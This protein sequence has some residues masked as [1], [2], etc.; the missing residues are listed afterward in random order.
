MTLSVAYP[1]NV[2]QHDPR[3][4]RADVR[5]FRARPG[6]PD[7][8]AEIQAALDSGASEITLG[9]TGFY[10]AAVTIPAGVTLTTSGAIL[11]PVPSVTARYVVQTGGVGA[12]LLGVTI[13]ASGDTGLLGGELAVQIRHAQARVSRC[14]FLATGYRYGVYIAAIGV[15]NC[16]NGEISDCEFLG[17]G[18]GIFKNG[19]DTSASWF[20]YLRNRLVGIARGDA[21]ELNVGADVGFVVED[22]IVDGV[23]ANGLPNAGIGI[24]IAGGSYGGPE[25]DQ[26]RYFRVAG[27]TV[28]NTESAAIHVEACNRGRVTGNTV[29][30]DSGAP[31]GVGIE[32]FGSTRMKVTANEATGFAVGIR[33][34]LGSNS[35][36]WILSSDKI[37]IADN[38]LDSCTLG[39]QDGT[40]GY[41][42]TAR[43]VRNRFVDCDTGI[44]VFGGAHHS[45]IGNQFADC[46]IPLALDLAPTTKG[47]VNA[48]TS[49]LFAAS[50][51]ATAGGLPQSYGCT[52]IN[53]S[54]A[55]VREHD[56]TFWLGTTSTKYDF[57]EPGDIVD[58][59]G[60]KLLCTVAGQQQKNG[61]TYQVTAIAG[62]S[63]LKVVSPAG[64]PNAGLVVGHAISV[65]GIGPGGATVKAVIRRIYAAAPDYRLDIDSVVATTVTSAATI[66]LVEISS[67]VTVTTT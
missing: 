9:D 17:T 56:N 43:I 62:N 40:A 29:L 47:S 67:F 28:R 63:Y 46:P 34:E 55:T 23:T 39:V 25:S 21:I 18:A 44:Q 64:D 54:V 30:R 45:V 32:I 66:A 41:R 59:A 8:S 13:D 24:G 57:H 51:T 5:D 10:R 61:G 7:S 52:L 49:S 12:R 11:K 19:V 35:G 53:A 36:A 58:D 31:A 3:P 27:N 2:G 38:D 4:P 6:D 14:A 37:V 15:G 33:N 26:D 60:A 48:V 50:N 16:D 42:K 22:N 20:R 65:P 1:R